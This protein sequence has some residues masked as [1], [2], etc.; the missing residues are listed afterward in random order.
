LRSA[1]LDYRAQRGDGLLQL[2][3]EDSGGNVY[4]VPFAV[5]SQHS[6]ELLQQELAQC[7]ADEKGAFLHICRAAVFSRF[8]IFPQVAD[9]YD[10]ALSLLPDSEDMLQNAIAV[11]E[12]IGN[13]PRAQALKSSLHT[14]TGKD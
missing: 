5:M 6:E 3:V 10:A 9:E 12:R 14:L 13:V 4:R 1:L 7:A 2:D 8:K 11:N